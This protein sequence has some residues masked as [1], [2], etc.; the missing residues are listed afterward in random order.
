MSYLETLQQQ[1]TEA[2]AR[3]VRDRQEELDKAAAN[4]CS[5]FIAE[6]K[7][8]LAENTADPYAVR[9]LTN[10]VRETFSVGEDLTFR[11][12]NSTQ[13]LLRKAMWAQVIPAETFFLGACGITN[14][15]HLS[16]KDLSMAA[17]HSASEAAK[18]RKE[19]AGI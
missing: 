1:A 13:D 19:T 4:E 9:C 14:D 5:K 18:Y 17:R 6:I 8:L 11:I 16:N 15:F 10:L 3:H 7:V 12:S 2:I